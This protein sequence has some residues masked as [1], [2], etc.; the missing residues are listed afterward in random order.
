MERAQP[1]DG[2]LP[3]R[4]PA[5]LPIESIPL[6]SAL[7][8][9]SEGVLRGGHMSIMA[10]GL[11]HT[12]DGA[13]PRYPHP[14]VRQ[15]A[16]LSAC[17]RVRVL[18]CARVC[19]RKRSEGRLAN[20]NRHAWWSAEQGSRGE[21]WGLGRDTEAQRHSEPTATVNPNGTASSLSLSLHSLSVPL[22]GSWSPLLR[23]PALGLAD[24]GRFN[25]T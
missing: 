10:G 2:T 19:A 17:V 12:S 23:I 7:R 18:A 9:C 13:R 4:G 16:R 14:R 24:S 20:L 5:V 25:T 11:P 22:T 3:G 8:N 21:W 6:L 1:T 15:Y